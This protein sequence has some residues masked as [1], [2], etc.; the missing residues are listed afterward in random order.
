VVCRLCHI[1]KSGGSHLEMQSRSIDSYV[2]AIHSFQAF[3]IGGVDFSDPVEAMR[4]EL[5]IEHVYPNFTIMNC[6]SCHNAGTFN[7]PDQS[8]SMPGVFSAATA[9]LDGWERTIGAVPSYVAGP[10]SRA[11]GACHRANLIKEDAAAELLS[12][13]QHTKTNGYL[14]EY[15]TSADFDTTCTTIMAAVGEYVVLPSP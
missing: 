9:S 3:D 5:H 10:G 14:V 15:T 6:K 11:C 2:H 12:F 13:N 1:T 7:V 4:Y 8:K